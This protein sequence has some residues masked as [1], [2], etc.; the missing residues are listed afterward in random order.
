MKKMLQDNFDNWEMLH[1]LNVVL[2]AIE[3][4]KPKNI[5]KKEN[6]W[7]GVLA[8]LMH[9]EMTVTGNFSKKEIAETIAI[10]E[11]IGKDRYKIGEISQTGNATVIQLKDKRLVA[12]IYDDATQKVSF[13][14]AE[15]GLRYSFKE[16]L[17]KEIVEE[18]KS[19]L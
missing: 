12:A 11:V 15:M 14:M 2:K 17:P 18:M 1:D 4:Q 3:T 7:Y 13:A 16:F 10:I 9:F 5:I 8:A 19:Q 6:K